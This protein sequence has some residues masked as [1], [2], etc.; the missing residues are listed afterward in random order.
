[1]MQLLALQRQQQCWRGLN[2]AGNGGPM[3]LHLLTDKAS[4]SAAVALMT[5]AAREAAQL[6]A[7]RIENDRTLLTDGERLQ[8]ECL[9]AC[10]ISFARTGNASGPDDP[11]IRNFVA[12]HGTGVLNVAVSIIHV[13]DQEAKKAKWMGW[14]GKAAAVG[15]GAAIAAFFG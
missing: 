8:A 7:H 2:K 13:A 3:N 5:P 9:Q 14:L 1:M 10:V 11:Q 12:N 4:I 15:A 6:L